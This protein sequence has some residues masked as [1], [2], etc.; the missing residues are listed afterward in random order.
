MPY[1]CYIVECADGTFYTGWSTDPQ[2]RVKVHNQGK[3]AKYTRM[4]GPVTLRYIEEQPDHST[5][6]KREREIKTYT[7]D[8][9]KAL[10]VS[11]PME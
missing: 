11:N 3:G 1:Y 4:R 10:I 7:H 2:R 9:K 6:L 8:R 5:A